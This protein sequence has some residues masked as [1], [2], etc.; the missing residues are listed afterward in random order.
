VVTGVTGAGAVLHFATPRCTA[1][2][3]LQFAVF[4]GFPWNCSISFSFSF[5]QGTLRMERVRV[6][7]GPD[8]KTQAYSTPFQS[9]SSPS[10]LATSFRTQIACAICSIQYNNT[11]T[12]GVS[13]SSKS[14][15][16][17]RLKSTSLCVPVAIFHPYHSLLPRPS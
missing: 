3:Y 7:N 17:S 1:T 9:I 5:W 6:P 2:P 16:V 4:H 12:I 13:S 8:L 14:Y 11:F 10:P 15:P